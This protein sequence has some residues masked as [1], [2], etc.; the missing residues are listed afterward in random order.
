MMEKTQSSTLDDAYFDRNQAA[1]A[2]ARVC[3]SYGFPFGVRADPNEPDWPV[4]FI[5]LPQ[6]QVSWHLPK[7]ELPGE[8]PTYD[9]PWDG[10]TLE[11]KRERIAAF[12]KYLSEEM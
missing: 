5:D 3:G 12:I 9:K 4:L 6:G 2:L 7:G 10:H 11:Q 8:W 1:M